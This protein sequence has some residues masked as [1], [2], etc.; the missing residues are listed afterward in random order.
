MSEQ[1]LLTAKFEKVVKHYLISC[2]EIEKKRND[3]EER[4]KQLEQQYKNVSNKAKQ[5]ETNLTLQELKYQITNLNSNIPEMEIRFGTNPNN[6]KPITHV[7]YLHI[8]D[9]LYA[10]GWK[11]VDNNV[12]G[13]NFL[14]IIP[15]TIKQQ[16][17]ENGKTNEENPHVYKVIMSKIRAELFDTYLIQDYCNHNDLEKMKA[18]YTKSQMKFTEKN[19][20]KD[21]STEEF[22]EKIDF[23]DY[24]FNVSYQ[25]EKDYSINSNDTRISKIFNDWNV[26]KKIFRSINRVRFEH[27]HYP[28]F[29]DLSIVKTNRKYGTKYGKGKYPLPKLTIQ[30]ADVFNTQPVY[31]V[32]LEMNNDK[33]KSYPQTEEAFAVLMK[34]IRQCIRVVLSGLQGTPYPISYKEQN[35]IIQDY[36]TYTHGEKWTETRKPEPYFIGPNS[37]ALQLANITKERNQLE[38]VPSILKG[39]TVTE[40]ADGERCLLYISNTGM[41]Y[42]ISYSM[43]V[44]FTGSRTHEKECWNSIVDGELIMYDK[45]HQLIFLFAAFDIYFIGGRK[46]GA[47]VRNLPFASYHDNHDDANALEKIQETRLSLLKTFYSIVKLTPVTK[48]ISDSCKFHMKVKQF[49]Y[50]EESKNKTILNASSEIWN[51]R[52]S[53]PYEIDGLIFTPMEYGVG[54]SKVGETYDLTGKFTWQYSF[55]WKPPKYNTIDFLVTT[56]KDKDGIDKI[57]FKVEDDGTVVEYKKLYLMV[58][59]DTKRNNFMNPFDEM[60][61]DKLPDEPLDK[62]KSTYIPTYQARNFVP[63]VPYDPTAYVCHMKLETDGD[64]KRMKTEEGQVF[65]KNM[66]IEFRYDTEDKTKSNHWRWIPLRIRHDKTQQLLEG[67]K[68]MNVYSNANDVWKSIHFPITAKMITGN[69][70][71]E[72]NHEATDTIYYTLVE[73]NVQYTHSL[74]DFHNLYVKSKL[75]VNLSE[76]L[77]QKTSHSEP[78]LLIDYA[79]GKA[80]DLNKWTRGNID[81][82]FGVDH[83]GDNIIN[84][85]DG[86]CVRYLRYRTMNRN[87][88]F[89]ALL[90]EGDSKLNIRTKG[91]AVEKVLEKDL[92]QYVFGQKNPQNAK[93]GFPY[94]IAKNGFH[95]SSCQFALHYFFESVQTIHNFIRNL[96]ECTRKD[97]YFIGTCFDGQ[98][99]FQKLH[100]VHQ[101]K[102]YTIMENG[103]LIFEIEKKYNTSLLHL[104]MNETSIGLPIVVY[105]ESIGQPIM[106]Y[107]VYFEYFQRLMQDYGFELIKQEEANRIGFP[108][109]SDTFESLYNSMKKEAKHKNI[110]IRDAQKMSNHEKEISFLNRY[111]IFKKV[112]ELSQSTLN[113]TQKILMEK[114]EMLQ[115]MELE[116]LNDDVA[117]EDDEIVDLEDTNNNDMNNDINNDTTPEMKTKNSKNPSNNT[118]KVK[119]EN[120]NQSRKIRKVKQKVI[121]DEDIYQNPVES[122]PVEPK[123]TEYRNEMIIESKKFPGAYYSYNKFTKVKRWLSPDE[124]KRYLNENDNK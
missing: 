52:E 117:Q 26:S 84:P 54:G 70:P 45:N 22:F 32:E 62:S 14:R 9:L 114:D 94:G 120:N 110:F 5:D 63:T 10:H 98:S 101:N 102:S 50:Y 23:P 121:L 69:E 6:I 68:S 91:D 28:V 87:D 88:K 77:K 16:L 40:K 83:S 116:N 44:M 48:N 38:S 19:S 18:K 4:R 34:E 27:S 67:K 71:V 12:K 25:T 90:I 31:E 15:E 36:M 8:V 61:Y 107:L 2:H 104:E 78:I 21:I 76:Y 37:I 115:N 29:V 65:D 100:G 53:F 55:K 97:G 47:N 20:I 3:L 95:I 75:I 58:G 13:K 1:E 109:A 111:F 17:N 80:G 39:Y 82:V 118:K 85:N 73:K 108:S 81:F 33:M 124:I 60:L 43:K 24:N 56:E 7:D 122:K 119:R 105:Q 30:E 11:P 123:P 113:N 106:E 64:K 86:A 99:V 41:A 42:L 46:K 103:K 92:I 49:H 112:T 51:K 66:I 35:Q 79:V 72:S 59:F 93:Y 74:R 96:A 89:R 57:H